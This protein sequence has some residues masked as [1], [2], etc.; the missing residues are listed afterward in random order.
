MTALPF[1]K[2]QGCG[3]DFILIDDRSG[4]FSGY[5][6]DAI[7]LLCHRRLGIG[8][9]GL[10]LLRH[11]TSADFQMVIFNADGSRPKMCGNGLRC[12]IA[13]LDHL[14]LYQPPRARIETD[15]GILE[16]RKEGSL[17][18]IHLE[19]VQ[20]VAAPQQVDGM[21]IDLV[22]SGVP[23][24]II[25]VDDLEGLNLVDLGR[26]IRFDPSFGEA[27][28]NVNFAQRTSATSIRFRTYERGVEAE[29]FSCGTGAAAIALVAL[30]RYGYTG[31]ILL[32]PCLLPSSPIHVTI[33]PR[34]PNKV[35]LIAEAQLVF[36]GSLNLS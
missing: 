29:T 32:E 5:S 2:Y 13:F 36:D 27:G 25:F 34:K 35:D 9:D 14:G 20:R 31:P 23:H 17:V 30:E 1:A 6:Q 8:A 11:S 18:G 21:R 24:G 19:P 7:S 26:K 12:L 10:V 28:I 4:R 16:G 33:D 22:N 3:N 15:M